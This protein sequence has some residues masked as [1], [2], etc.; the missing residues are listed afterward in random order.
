MAGWLAD[1][2]LALL[3]GGDLATALDLRGGRAIR[4]RN[5]RLAEIA[6]RLAPGA[7]VG[8]QAAL[9]AHHVRRALR[10]QARSDIAA[11]IRDLALYGCVPRSRRQLY[12]ILQNQKD[13]AQKHAIY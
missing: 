2:R 10:D 5:R 1:A 11:D 9:L 8:R 13:I 12:T 6:H 7:A 3:E 4:D